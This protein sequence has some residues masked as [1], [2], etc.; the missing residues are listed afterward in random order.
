M[1]ASLSSKTSR[2]HVAFSAEAEAHIAHQLQTVLSRADD[3]KEAFPEDGP[4][5]LL[6][7]GPRRHGKSSFINTLF[8]VGEQR[9]GRPFIKQA[10]SGMDLRV[11]EERMNYIAATN[12]AS[13]EAS[14]SD[15]LL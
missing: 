15:E 3:L 2:H 5:R 13:C 8:H 6:L 7:I 14:D 10:A 12:L 4:L 11:W 1:G 9:W